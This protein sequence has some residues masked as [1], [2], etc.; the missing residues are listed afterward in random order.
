MDSLSYIIFVFIPF[1][2]LLFGGILWIVQTRANSRID[3][4]LSSSPLPGQ[5]GAAHDR[6][7]TGNVTD[8]SRSTHAGAV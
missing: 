3:A 6:R 5:G 2:I 4:L 1:L 7:E 8:P